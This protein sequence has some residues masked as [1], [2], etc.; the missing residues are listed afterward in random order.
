M[1]SS[2]RPPLS[3]PRIAGFVSL[4]LLCALSSP[5]SA[6]SPVTFTDVAPFPG[7]GLDG[8]ER[9]PSARHAA[10]E[11]FMSDSL[12]TP[13]NPFVDVIVTPMRHRGIPGVSLLDFDSDG[14]LD[15]YVTNGPGSPNSLFSNQLVET[16]QMSFIDVAALAGVEATSQDSNGSCFGDIDNDGDPD[17]MVVGHESAPILYENQGGT[18]SDISQSAGIDSGLYGMSCVMGDVDQNGLLDIFVARGY[19]LNTLFECFT[20]IFSPEIQPNDLFLNQ[21]HNTFSDVS[22]SSGIRDL[23]SGGMPPGANTISWSAA[24]VDYDLDGDLD[25]MVTDDQCNVPNQKFGG[26]SRGTLQ[27][28]Q[29]DGSAQFTNVTL[30]AGLS[31]PSEWMGTS[32][33][34]F[35][36]DGAMDFFV[37]SFGDWGKQFVGAPIEV[38]D[39]S[40]RWYLGNAQGGFTDPGVGDMRYTPF[41]WGTVA[42]DFDNDGHT[43]LAFHGGLDMVTLMEKSNPGAILFNDGQANFTYEPEALN[44]R[45][46]RRND[47]G[48]AAGDLDD[49]GYVDIVSVSNFNTPAPMALISYTIGGIDYGTVWDPGLFVPMMD[50]WQSGGFAW[51]GTDATNGTLSVELNNGESGHRSVQ[52]KALGTAGLTPGG[53]NNRDGIGAVMTFTPRHGQTAMK[54]VLGGSSHASQDSLAQYFGLG[55]SHRGTLEV[56]WPGGV[57]NRLYNVRAGEKVTMPEIPCGYDDASI[58]DTKYALCV[59]KSLIYLV[60]CNAISKNESRR[61]FVSAIRARRRP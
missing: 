14:D 38:G 10:Y 26:L 27:L 41:G 56:L 9:T 45:H 12:I 7:V 52:V 17:L 21:G 28:F 29:N 50:E 47:S 20:D 59:F 43:D 61:L 32:W 15:V 48:V 1:I 53:V 40:S 57:R 55:T 42:E 24:L 3:R 35:N 34:D 36:H 5:A 8:Y 11:Q 51:N 60:G 31:L 18:F 39:E 13:I 25:L 30:Q 54:P 19:S 16:G 49:D 22:D 2:H 44:E 37:T 33:G 4:A 23:V 58:N 6:Y 46:R